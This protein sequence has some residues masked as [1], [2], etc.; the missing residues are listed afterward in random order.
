MSRL[1][2]RLPETLHQQLVNIAQK[3]GRE[4]VTFAWGGLVSGQCPPTNLQLFCASL[5]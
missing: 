4:R 1:T 5:T 3:E 2:V